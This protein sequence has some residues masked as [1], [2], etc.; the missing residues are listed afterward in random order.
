MSWT[1]LG[2][3]GEILGAMGVIAT[4]LY[5]S[6]Q[7]RASTREMRRAA[8]QEVLD[9]AGQF[10]DRL[11]ARPE[12]A[13]VWS[14]GLAADPTLTPAQ[15][16]QFRIFALRWTLL[17]ERLFRMGEAGELESWVAQNH[18]ENRRDIAATPGYQ[19]W[20]ESRGHWVS[21]E[22][23]AVLKQ[24]LIAGRRVLPDVELSERLP[25]EDDSQLGKAVERPAV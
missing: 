15:Q 16:T 10:L 12:S 21:R 6:R 25:R 5:L 8:T 20:L 17:S 18:S 22:F 14:K 2:A 23:R 7:I 13:E 4:L 24:D 19:A 11:G 9:Q 3:M 1:A